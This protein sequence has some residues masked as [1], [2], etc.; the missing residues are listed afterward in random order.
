MRPA[1]ASHVNLLEEPEH[2]GAPFVFSVLFHAGIVA[3]M[4]GITAIEM[5]RNSELMGDLHPGAGVAITAV[6]TIP[7]QR[8]QGEINRLAND[9]ETIVPQAPLKL[10]E[11]RPEQKRQPEKAIELPTEKPLKIQ[12]KPVSQ[13]LYRP[14]QDYKPNQ[15]F[16]HT[17][18][19]LVSPQVGLQGAGGVGIGAR[20]PFGY[21][22]S[23]YAQQIRDLIASKWSQSGIA[24]PPSAGATVTIHIA[25]DGSVQITQVETSG[26]Y[27]LDT[28]AKRA[29]L[30][31]NPL[32]PLPP[33]FPRN[34][35]S[36]DLLFSLRQ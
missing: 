25:R 7:I 1:A 26:N 5:K 31:A 28:S 9:T 10:R 32:P 6:K 29:V 19:A 30:D 18:P 11:Q 8:K 16:S 14:H 4:I 3:L 35:A 15:V 20:S 17:A 36:V 21:Q 24:A 33:G 13:N 12:P 27:A 22:F 23:G 34:D 2:L